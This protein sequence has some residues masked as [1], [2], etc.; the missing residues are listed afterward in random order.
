MEYVQPVFA[1]VSEDV[2][3]QRLELGS[4]CHGRPLHVRWPMVS[5]LCGTY[6]RR[7]Q[8][9][10]APSPNQLLDQWLEQLPDNLRFH[11]SQIPHGSAAQ[12]SLCLDF[13]SVRAA[14]YRPFVSLAQQ[15]PSTMLEASVASYSKKCLE[16][17]VR[18]IER[19]SVL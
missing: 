17:S 1:A 5:M 2:G 4:A 11:E 15:D 7:N 6:S 14:I 3:A 16:A 10:P 13:F 18:Q 8:A 9:D 19:V 12:T